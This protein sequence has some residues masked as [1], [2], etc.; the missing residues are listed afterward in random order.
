MLPGLAEERPQ[1]RGLRPRGLMAVHRVL[2]EAWLQV[3]HSPLAA[4]VP[5]NYHEHLSWLRGP[6]KR[7]RGTKL[8]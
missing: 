5:R 6:S 2:D 1:T 3:L 7:K 4:Q 8:S